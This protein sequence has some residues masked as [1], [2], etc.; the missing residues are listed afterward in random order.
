MRYIA[1]HYNQRPDARSQRESRMERWKSKCI[2]MGVPPEE[3]SLDV[4]LMRQDERRVYQGGYVRFA[5]LVYRGEYLAGYAGEKVALR[6]DP[7]DITTLYVYRAEGGYDTF[8]TR[9]HAM[10]LEAERLSLIDAK[11]IARRLRESR[12]EI[13]NPAI[14]NEIR[15][16]LAEPLRERMAFVKS[17]VEERAAALSTESSS[18][19]SPSVLDEAPP[20]V[21]APPESSAPGQS[22]GSPEVSEEEEEAIDLD[23]LPEVRVY[24]TKQLR[25]MRQNY[26]L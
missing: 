5:N 18:K 14:L 16:A 3:R 19:P 24:D 7:R 6:Y 22:P 9:A 15:D 21:I 17:V 13:N 4:L 1:D 20:L 2:A 12:R 10:N 25:Q 8:L 11:A 23:S 26:G